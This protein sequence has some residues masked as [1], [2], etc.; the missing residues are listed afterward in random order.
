MSDPW[1]SS[2]QKLGRAAAHFR[3]LHDETRSYVRDGTPFEYGAE[4]D[5]QSGR[6]RVRITGGAPPPEDASLIVGDF[7][8]NLRASLDHLI[9]AA[10]EANGQSPTS[11]N[12]F[13][14]F[15]EAP[16]HGRRG[17]EQWNRQL[18]GLATAAFPMIE[19]VQ[20][21]KRGD[22]AE[23][24]PLAW[25]RRLSNEDKHRVVLQT[26]TAIPAPDEAAP[27]LQFEVEDMEEIESF[28]LHAR[29]PLAVGDLVMEAAIKITGPN[30]NIRFKGE[31]PIELAFGE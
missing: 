29:K 13:P 26:L 19:H 25:L 7:I 9:W 16:E 27:D 5:R 6:F 23:Q 31:L 28:E 18:R 10:V 12:T 11:G 22:K 17:K 1:S 14:I 21:Y 24:A 2:L 30:P 20:P 8:Q 3:S 4:I 15:T